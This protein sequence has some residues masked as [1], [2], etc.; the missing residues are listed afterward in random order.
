MKIIKLL[1]NAKKREVIRVPGI[2][3]GETVSISGIEYAIH[4]DVRSNKD[5]YHL[6]FVGDKFD[7]QFSKNE[8]FYVGPNGT[9]GIGNRYA[10]FGDWLD[11]ANF[12]TVPDVSITSAGTINFDN[13]RHRYAWMRDHGAV[14]VP[15]AMDGDS[16]ERA[17]ELEFIV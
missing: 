12:V 5:D 13:G 15:V 1:E 3:T 14:R 9:G 8:D 10:R 4:M 11:G 16:L 2:D 7:Q 17:R 6:V